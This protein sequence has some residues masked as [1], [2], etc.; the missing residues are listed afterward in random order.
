MCIL[1]DY[2]PFGPLDQLFTYV[3]GSVRGRLERSLQRHRED[4]RIF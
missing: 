1:A 4:E 2:C 3:W